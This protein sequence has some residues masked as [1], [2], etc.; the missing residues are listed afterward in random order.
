VRLPNL[1]ALAILAALSATPMLANAQSSATIAGVVTSDSGMPIKG[2][3]VFLEYLNIGTSTR[4]DG[5]YSLIIPPARLN[6]QRATLTA[7]LIGYATVRDT[8][9]LV[10]GEIKHNFV[11]ASSPWVICPGDTTT[12]ASVTEKPLSRREADAYTGAPIDC[13]LPR[14]IINRILRDS[15]TMAYYAELLQGRKQWPRGGDTSVVLGFIAQSGDPRFL[16]VLLLYARVDSSKHQAHWRMVFSQAVGG[17]VRLDTLPEAH[18]RLL[19][20]GTSDV[21]AAYREI[22]AYL[23]IMQHSSVARELLAQVSTS[24]C[25]P[26]LQAHVRAALAA[27]PPP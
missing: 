20:L 27:P 23:L 26:R 18:D 13:G 22:L 16:P 14:S 24:D 5:S 17:L 3:Q 11:L 10:G 21:G 9:V 2:A 12:R 1:R 25:S 7:R 6:G 19:A 15:T 4:D 8:I